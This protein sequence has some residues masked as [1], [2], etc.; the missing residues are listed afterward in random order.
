MSKKPKKK[1]ISSKELYNKKLDRLM[2]STGKRTL[3]FWAMNNL[4]DGTSIDDFFK[5]NY[6]LV[7]HDIGRIYKG[8]IGFHLYLFGVFPPESA[9]SKTTPFYLQLFYRSAYHRE[10]SKNP[11]L[12]IFPKPDLIKKP[13]KKTPP[14]K[15]SSEPKKGKTIYVS[16]PNKKSK[17]PT[18]IHN[19]T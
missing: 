12:N 2:N 4:E 13:A 1:K 7:Y 14:K 18:R 8:L 16:L 6:P 15:K 11:D 5:S 19:F 9:L 10:V 3:R 17:R